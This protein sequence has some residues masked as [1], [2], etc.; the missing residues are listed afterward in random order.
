[1][2]LAAGCAPVFAQVTG[3]NTAGAGVLDPAAMQII[4][5]SGKATE[6][7]KSMYMEATSLVN[8]TVNGKSNSSKTT[9]RMWQQ[10]PKSYLITQGGGSDMTLINDGKQ[11]MIYYPLKK[12]YSVLPTETSSTIAASAMGANM[13]GANGT[14][15]LKKLLK[16]ASVVG[17]E[18]VNG[19]PTKHLKVQM[20]NAPADMWFT[21]SPT[22]VMVRM[23]VNVNQGA[24]SMQNTTDM[25]YVL[26]QA[27]PEATFNIAPPPGA[28][29]VSAPAGM[30]MGGAPAAEPT[31]A[32]R[33]DRPLPR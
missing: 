30:G 11:M 23:S 31:A 27:I 15:A 33:V 9:M 1:M 6:Q 24:F 17:T 7:A 18:T 3:A 8:T 28:T 26:N 25:K 10:K 21:D 16:S 5:Q 22:P 2:A 4:E 20:G 29:Q 12:Q 32:S 14:E 13:A 19:Q